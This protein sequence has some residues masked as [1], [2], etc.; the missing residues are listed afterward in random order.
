MTE[1]SPTVSQ[2]GEDAVLAIIRE[3]LEPHNSAVAESGL[4]LGPGDDAA[5]LRSVAGG[6]TVLTTDTM[7]QDRDFRLSWWKD[8]DAGAYDIGIKAAAQN[9]SDLSA[10]GAVPRALLV[11]LTLPAETTVSWVKAFCAGLIRA[12]TADRT[13]YCAV[14]GGDLGSAES[15]S[16]TITAVGT[17]GEDGS[18]LTRAGAQP[19]ERLAIAGPLGRAAAGLALLERPLSAPAT[20]TQ[21]SIWQKHRE[22]FT[23]CL[24]AQTRPDPDLGAGPAALE[25]GA[26][27]GMDISDGLLRDAR[28]LAQ[29]SGVRLIIDEDIIAADAEALTPVARMLGQGTAAA[30]DWVLNGGEDYALLATFP[31]DVEVPAG[32]RTIGYV[33]AGSPEAVT[34]LRPGRDGWDSLSD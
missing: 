22:V 12:C 33:E 19:G 1:T 25:A 14:A 23:A 29:A 17:L 8:A 27:A 2:E 18:A 3:T 20:E 6:D 21:R 5:V 9:L 15:I 26:T 31:H 28:R 30:V 32:F 4:L 24:K 13:P 10:M 11:S 16:V 34:Q 7:S